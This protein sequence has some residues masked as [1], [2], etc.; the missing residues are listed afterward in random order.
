MTNAEQ[1]VAQLAS[2][3][4]SVW[5]QVA[6]TLLGAAFTVWALRR[7]KSQ[8][9]PKPLTEAEVLDPLEVNKACEAMERACT[10]VTP[11]TLTVVE[12][13][14]PSDLAL[15]FLRPLRRG[16]RLLRSV[17]GPS[18]SP[19]LARW[20]PYLSE[21]ALAGCEQVEFRIQHDHN[22]EAFTLHD[23]LV[24]GMSQRP[25]LHDRDFA[26][27]SALVCPAVLA[28]H[29]MVACDMA[30]EV[31]KVQQQARVQA[32][33]Q[34]AIE[35]CA[36]KNEPRRVPSQPESC[37]VPNPLSALAWLNKP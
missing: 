7:G 36:S 17:R 23:I 32:E 12:V 14:E 19:E 22:F 4:S 37:P 9:Q 21:Y 24:R 13:H 29:E 25:L 6:V 20:M 26:A 15:Q 11:P 5:L 35:R 8:A 1:F 33:T 16:F 3:P 2:V 10:L 30:E 27:I 34:K 28:C 18:V 31:Q